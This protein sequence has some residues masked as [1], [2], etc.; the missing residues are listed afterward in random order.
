MGYLNGNTITVDAILTKHGRRLLAE[1][2]GLNISKFGFSDDGIDY[3]LYN[4]DHPDGSAKY[5]EAITD[6]PQLEAVPDDSVVM[7]YKLMTLDRNTI[8]M[9]KIIGIASSIT[10]DN[11]SDKKKISPVTENATDPT[12]MFMFTDI[13]AV[14][15]TGGSRKD[16]GGNQRTFLSSAEIPQAATFI[17]SEITIT[18]KPTDT[19]RNI[20][21]Q[22]TG[23]DTGAISYI[24]IAISNNIRTL[25]IK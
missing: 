2:K 22:V 8:F 15:I 5:G 24:D 11:Q 19:T 16:I 23:M 12:Y 25:A 18:A 9:P 6:L 10:L 4:P 20:T 1:G 14:N 17:G 21:V 7:K 13:S 3:E